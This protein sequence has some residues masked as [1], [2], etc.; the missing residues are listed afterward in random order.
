MYSV[1]H[2]SGSQSRN[3][4]R[5]EAKH[6]KA[7]EELASILRGNVAAPEWSPLV[8]IQRGG[9]RPRF[10]C[11]HGAGGNVLI[12]RD[13]ARHMESEQPFYGLQ[14]QGL[15][16][17]RPILSRIESMAALYV[18]EI[19]R[20][21]PHGPYFLGGYCMGGTVALEMAQQ[22]KAQGEQVALLALFDT[23]NWSKL[24]RGT[25]RDKAYYE[26]QRLLFHTGN[27]LL[28]NSRNQFKFLRAKLDVLRSRIPVWRG[29]LLSQVARGPQGRPGESLSRNGRRSIY[30]KR[31][32]EIWEAND[33]ASMQYLAQ[34]YQ[35]VITDF[36]PVKQYARYKVP[37]AHWSEL[38]Q[39]R[40]EIV[41]LPVYPAGMLLEPF[42][43]HLAAALKSAI[44]KAA[45]LPAT[46]QAAQAPCCVLV[47]NPETPVAHEET[48]Q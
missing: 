25:V 14:S 1:R 35:G 24:R 32:L 4:N 42:V 16:G 8:E 26:V 48:Y 5:E 41:T 28:L 23:I 43:R 19:Q 15:D 47:A 36:R 7:N 11:A 39:G 3:D 12:Y 38:T 33:L 18:K 30:M 10:F 37:G 22:L 31:L 46:G 29:M 20:V 34:P 40:E 6:N 17:E 2:R 13:L 27:F 44:D 21:Q 45:T 9:A